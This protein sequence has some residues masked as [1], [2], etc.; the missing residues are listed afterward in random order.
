MC[1]NSSFFAQHPLYH[2]PEG[3]NFGGVEKYGILKLA[4]D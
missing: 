4:A 1:I 3:Y 2:H